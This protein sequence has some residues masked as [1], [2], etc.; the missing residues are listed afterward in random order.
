MRRPRHRR[1][2]REDMVIAVGHELGLQR[3][4]LLLARVVAPLRRVV[5]GAG[6]PLLGRVDQRPP[7][8]QLSPRQH[9]LGGE[10]GRVRDRFPD[11]RAGQAG[12]QRGQ[13]VAQRARD[14][15][16]A[17]PEQQP[18]HLL[19]DMQPQI[20]QHRRHPQRQWLRA[21]PPAPD[22]PLAVGARPPHPLLVGP[23]PADRRDQR[24]ELLRRQAR[25]CLDHARILPQ[26]LHREH[27]RTLPATH[28]PG[29]YTM[30]TPLFC[31]NSSART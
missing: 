26:T 1:A 8:G 30:F 2:D 21:V 27:G 25:E 18:D 14:R 24:P 17:R 28:T 10:R 6:H 15:G 23:P 9:G 13:H 19:R 4:R 7:V 3:V 20:R 5:A 31:I 29:G 22:R 12:P 16:L 11:R